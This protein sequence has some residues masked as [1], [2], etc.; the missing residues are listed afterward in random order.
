V[1]RLR[2]KGIPGLKGGPPGD[3]LLHLKVTVPQSPTD[4]QKKLYDELR[5]ASAG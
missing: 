5:K 3:L 2:G 1:M 4:E